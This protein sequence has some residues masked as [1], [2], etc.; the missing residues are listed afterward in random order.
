[1]G[2][3]LVHKES[4]RMEG[5]DQR[6]TLASTAATSGRLRGIVGRLISGVETTHLMLQATGHGCRAA[7]QKQ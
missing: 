1:M 4:R 7:R 2:Y 5:E 6:A 3:L